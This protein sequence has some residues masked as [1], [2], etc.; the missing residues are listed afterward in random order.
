MEYLKDLN[1]SQACIRAGYSPKG[2]NVT[3]SQ[4]L[5]NPSIAR[6]IAETQA[7]QLANTGI[8]AEK[9]LEELRRI[10]FSDL[11]E[12]FTDWG[13]LKPLHELT[14][15]QAAMVASFEVVKKNLYAGDKK[16]DTVHKIKVWDKLKAL[17]LLAKHLNLLVERVN[18]TARLDEELE[19]RLLMGRQASAARALELTQ[20]A[21]LP[22]CASARG[23]H[24][25]RRSPRGVA[26]GK[27]SS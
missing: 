25:R 15:E 11:R 6:E 8:S 13:A 14:A 26:L 7:V 12:L 9:T 10:A 3:G 23:D 20:R 1:A 16:T 21:P 24:G 27:V 4:L 5:A 19:R 2:S 18:V 22:F 17:E